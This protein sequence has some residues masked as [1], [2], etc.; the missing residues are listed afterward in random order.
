MRVAGLAE[1]QVGGVV[2]SWHPSCS[3]AAQPGLPGQAGGQL[4][5]AG[6]SWGL[7]VHA[8]ARLA[9]RRRQGPAEVRASSFAAAGPDRSPA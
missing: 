8:P 3:L 7:R 9:E 5:P 2:A 1:G 4:G 6:P